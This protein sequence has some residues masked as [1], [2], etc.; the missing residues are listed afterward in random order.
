[1]K[2]LFS[3]KATPSMLHI[4]ALAP[5]IDI[6]TILVV[7][8]LK[9]SSAVAPPQLPEPQ[10]QLPISAQKQSIQQPDTVDI[11]K[12]GIYFN[13]NRV[14]SRAYWEQQSAPLIQELYESM[15]ANPPEK[16]QIRADSAVPWTLIDKTLATARQAGCTDVELLAIQTDSL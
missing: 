13:G 9:S 1:M 8:V 3:R 11:G 14:S 6:F 7:A 15:L 4:A 2:R 16:L 12:D 5:L 10:T